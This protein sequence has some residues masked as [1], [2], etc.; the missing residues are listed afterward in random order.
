M[1]AVL[2]SVLNPA[3]PQAARID[4]LWWLMFWVATSVFVIVFA[5]GHCRDRARRAAQ[6]KLTRRVTRG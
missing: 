6:S 4:W 5:F 1:I 3:G 2:E